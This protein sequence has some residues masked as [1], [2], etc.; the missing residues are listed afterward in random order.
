VQLPPTTPL[1]RAARAGTQAQRYD[2]AGERVGLD[3]YIVETTR[4]R[5]VLERVYYAVRATDHADA[6]RR[7][8]TFEGAPIQIETI[9]D[10]MPQERV[11]AVRHALEHTTREE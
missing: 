10:G 8:E 6:G 11:Q 4:T 5:V 2:V 7:F 1:E 9:A 3:L